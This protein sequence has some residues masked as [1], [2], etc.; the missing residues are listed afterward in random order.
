M[1]GL[2][3]GIVTQSWYASVA[4]RFLSVFLSEFTR[5]KKN[6]APS[7]PIVLQ[8][9]TIVWAMADFPVFSEAKR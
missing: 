1:N 3:S 5:E 7:I 6:D 2:S 9:S 4:I 8:Y